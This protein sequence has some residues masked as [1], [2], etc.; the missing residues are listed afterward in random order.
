MADSLGIGAAPDAESFGD[1]GANTLA[2][3]LAAYHGETGQK[4][5]LPNLSKLGLID[6]CEEASNTSC[7][8]AERNAPIAAYGYA[9]EI[10]SGKDTPS[11][12]WEMAGVPVLFDWGYFHDK[13]NSFPEAFIEEFI[14]RANLP[15]ILGNCHSSGTVILE[16]LGEEHMLTG[17]PI[18]YTSTD[19]VFQIACHEETVGLERLY[20]ICEIAREL[21]N[22]YNIGRVIARPFLGD[23]A[24]NFVR[25]GNRR[26]YSVLPPAPTLLDKLA[27]DNGAVISIGKISD[28]YAHQG[29][30]EKHKAPGLEN[31][32]AKTVE[33]FGSANDHSLTFVNLVDFDEKFGHRRD[34]IGYAKALK[35]LDDYLPE[36][37]ALLGRDDVLMITADHGC[38]PTWQG[39]DHTREYVPVI[40]Y[41]PGMNAV[42]LGERG[43]FADIGQT[44]AQWFSL[45]PLEYGNSF[46]SQ[47][48]S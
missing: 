18:C 14:K 4:L 41:T 13:Q 6:A 7:Q 10:S 26:D 20:E 34:A 45:E 47:L 35:Q 37:L 48:G 38:D 40:A 28:I 44:L 17:K 12:H 11:G 33:V 9:K 16:A 27:A 39:T 3:L 23:A 2:H 24:D 46:K 8:V 19:S 30:T 22:E 1:K 15:G 43:T 25:T 32:M 29:I 42:N 5:A 36:F 31:L 21:L